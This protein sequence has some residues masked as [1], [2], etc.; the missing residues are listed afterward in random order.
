MVEQQ[1]AGYQTV[2]KPIIHLQLILHLQPIVPS[3]QLRTLLQDKATR[4]SVEHRGTYLQ[5]LRKNPS[6]CAFRNTSPS[7]ARIVLMN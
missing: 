7:A 4:K 5:I 6:R 2:S 1:S 3:L